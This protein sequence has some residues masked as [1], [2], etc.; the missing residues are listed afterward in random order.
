[1][2]E[3]MMTKHSAEIKCEPAKITSSKLAQNDARRVNAD[4]LARESL[5]TQVKSSAASLMK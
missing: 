1:M 4:H 5:M 2:C 3:E